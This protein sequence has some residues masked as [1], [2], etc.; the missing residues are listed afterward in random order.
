MKLHIFALF[1][2]A[3]FAL[4]MGQNSFASYEDARKLRE[5]IE[6]KWDNRPSVLAAPT[7]TV[8]LRTTRGFD[9]EDSNFCWDFS[10]IN[11]LE[12]NYLQSHPDVTPEEV[13]LSRWYMEKA[14]E[15]IYR[16]G[17][18]MDA[19]YFYMPKIGL[20]SLQDYPEVGS[21]VPEQT[22][23]RGEPKTPFELKDVIFDEQVFWSY[24]FSNKKQGWD[25]HADS[26]ALE[27]TQ[28]FYVKPEKAPEIINQ[29]LRDGYAV[30][31]TANGHSTIIYGADFDADGTALKYF[32]KDS[33]DPYFYEADANLLF[34]ELLEITTIS[35]LAE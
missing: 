7:E 5:K 28:S 12:T 19:L 34:D 15:S 4:G 35:E 18:T 1:F 8:T 32:I 29:S 11:M 2:A 31:F 30:E 17:T 27:G 14:T 33:Y 24:A 10:A 22:N 9:Q 23:F 25:T 26:D 13:E 6:W 20:L 21:T 3:L 16:R